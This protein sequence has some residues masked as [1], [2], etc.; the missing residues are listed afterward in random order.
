MERVLLVSEYFE[1]VNAS[2]PKSQNITDINGQGKAL[3]HFITTWNILHCQNDDKFH[4]VHTYK[5]LV[6]SQDKRN[7]GVH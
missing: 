1:R 2:F 7:E 4:I 3:F 5:V 6:K